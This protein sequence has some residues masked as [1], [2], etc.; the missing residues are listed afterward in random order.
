MGPKLG[1]G[2][3]VEDKLGSGLIVEDKVS[4]IENL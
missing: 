4:F 1:S 2:L 3:I